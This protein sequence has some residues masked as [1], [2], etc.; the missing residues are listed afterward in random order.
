M[1]DAL[2]RFSHT[3]P[4]ALFA[5]LEKR[6]FSLWWNTALS[7][8]II[9]TRTLAVFCG[10]LLPGALLASAL[11]PAIL[12]LGGCLKPTRVILCGCLSTLHFL[13]SFHTPHRN[14]I[15]DD[16]I[17]SAPDPLLDTPALV[18]HSN[19]RDPHLFASP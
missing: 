5:M 10:S 7:S 17:S 18:P 3:F 6:F 13:T 4:N 8:S 12:F 16:H 14:G 11:L 19:F 2:H 15:N 1:G 9:D